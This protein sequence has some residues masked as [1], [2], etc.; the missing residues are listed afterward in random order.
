MLL[1]RTLTALVLAPLVILL[2]LLS[3]TAVFALI[4]AAAFLAAL[5]EWAQLSGLKNQSARIGLLVAAAVVFA[6]LWYGHAGITTPVL[7]AAGVAWWLL[8]CLWLRHFAFGA[9][10]TAENRTL[11]LLAGA[12]VLFPAW[13]ALISIHERE[14]HGH[15]WTL[16]ALVIVWAADIG[17]YFSGRTFGKR[18]LAPQISPG[19]TWA[20]AYGA[21]VAG[22]VVTLLGGWLLDV[23]GAPLLGL[24]LLALLTVAV[25]IVGDLIES[26]MKRHAQVKDSGTIIPGHG[27][28]MDRLDSVF[29]A[30]PVFAAGLLL[31][32]L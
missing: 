19:K 29:A 3:S 25:S 5:W 11:K 13:I 17:A 2:I 26:L 8:A 4:A 22:V 16:L 6:L 1:Q 14:P 28:L 31:L 24:A 9:A 30:L 21:L 23:R 12:F 27:G 32:G 18:K 15:W 10:P 20:G 7:L